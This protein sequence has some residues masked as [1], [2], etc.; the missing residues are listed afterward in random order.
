L[1]GTPQIE[2]Q[3]ED[4]DAAILTISVGADFVIDANGTG[5]HKVKLA[6]TAANGFEAGKSYTASIEGTTPTVDTISVLG[7]QIAHMN[8]QFE[9]DSAPAA[10]S[11]IHLDHLLAVDYD[12]AS[13]PGIAT[14]LLNE[15]VEDD[16][17]GESRFTAIALSEAPVS[18]GGFLQETYRFDS[19]IVAADPG[20]G[21]VRWDSATPASVTEVYISEFD[22]A[23]LNQAATIEALKAGDSLTISEEGNGANYIRGT[24]DSVPTDNGVWYTI[25]VTVVESGTLIGN[26]RPT[27]VQFGYAAA[28]VAQI[29]DGVWDESLGAHNIAGSTG[30][31]LKQLKEGVISYEATVDDATPTT[32][33]F[34]TDLPNAGDDAKYVDNYWIDVNLV[35][36]S[37]QNIGVGR[38]VSGYDQ[39]TRTI[40]LDEAFP[41]TP[42]DTDEFIILAPH[43]HSVTQMALGFWNTLKATAFTALSMGAL[44]KQFVFT[45]TGRV[46]SN[47]EAVN[48]DTAGAVILNKAVKATET[49]IVG[50]GVH[51]VSLVAASDLTGL[52][53]DAPRYSVINFTSGLNKGRHCPVTAYNT[54]TGAITLDPLYPL[55]SVPVQNDTFTLT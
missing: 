19:S 55:P 37:G 48:N 21:D 46:D 33:S 27:A 4:T 3:E 38:V 2:V 30:K 42:A 54:S 35:F 28:T 36:I 11:N 1:A 49:G 8:C 22:S 29:A 40:T 25:G 6:C 5:S 12:P 32:T 20:S 31:A 52:T 39:A 26:N 43:I 51:T 7:T 14:A 16:G 44:L 15:L 23:G 45:G 10:L 18:G 13:P 41:N 47:V 9:Y 50:A 53:T 17:G 34:V 24:V